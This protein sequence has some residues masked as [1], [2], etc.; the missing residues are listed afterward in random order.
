MPLPPAPKR[1]ISPDMKNLLLLQAMADNN[2]SE[3][4]RLKLIDWYADNVYAP[5]QLDALGRRIQKPK[6]YDMFGRELRPTQTAIKMAAI[7]WAINYLMPI[8]RPTRLAPKRDNMSA[9]PR[10]ADRSLIWRKAVYTF[11]DSNYRARKLLR[12]ILLGYKVTISPADS[13]LVARELQH[14]ISDICSV[15]PRNPHFELVKQLN[16]TSK[17]C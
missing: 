10:S 6:K 14:S 15:L 17:G 11:S 13:Q 5:E 3:V 4:E 12:Y 8:R 9:R 2:P 7:R 1:Q 16:A